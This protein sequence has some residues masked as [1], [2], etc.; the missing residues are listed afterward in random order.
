MRRSAWRSRRAGALL[1]LVVLSLAALASGCDV[2]VNLNNLGGGCPPPAHGPSQVKINTSTGA[3]AAA[4]CIDS[5]EVTNAQYAQFVASGF[6]IAQA[7]VPGPPDGGAGPCPATMSTSTTGGTGGM[8][9]HSEYPI[10]EVNWCQAYAYC[11]WA[12][13]RLCGEIGGG[14][15]APANE[16]VAK[17]SQ[18]YDACSLGGARLYPYGNTFNQ[19]T[20]GGQAA[21]TSVEPVASSPG[22]VGSIPGV[23]DMSGNVWEWTDTCVS[24]DPGGFCQAFGGGFDSTSSDLA[25]TGERNWT[26]SSGAADIGIRCCSDL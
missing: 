1:A 23:Y 11:K 26:R 18:W 25:C 4:F 12:G 19:G 7:A 17:Y 24:Y 6:T 21:G 13:K 3:A 5:T 9:G 10:T 22:C 20:C 15:L 16:G 8:P 14:A 2:A